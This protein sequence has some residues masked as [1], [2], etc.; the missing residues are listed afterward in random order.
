MRED[1]NEAGR[2][3]GVNLAVNVAL[4]AQN[5]II[6]LGSRRPGGR[7]ARRGPQ[8]TRALRPEAGKPLLTS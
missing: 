5:K 3:V 4:D 8:N 6:A 7:P 1:L 2:I